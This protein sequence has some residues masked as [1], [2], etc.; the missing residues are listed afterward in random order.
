MEN[1]QNDPI[2]LNKVLRRVKRLP[3]SQLIE[4]SDILDTWDSGDHREYQRRVTKAEVDVVIEDRYFK[5]FSKDISAGGLFINTTGRFEL[6]KKVKMV[7]EFPG[8]EKPYKLSGKIVR[9]EDAGIAIE[10][11]RNSPLF[12][13]LM[14]DAIWESKKESDD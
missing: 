4:L 2:L 12:H 7:F 5:A 13:K 14:D 8:K 6:F 11:D 10:F 3:K 1:D 9:I